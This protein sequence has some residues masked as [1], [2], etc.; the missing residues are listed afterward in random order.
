MEPFG[1][2]IFIRLLIASI[3]KLTPHSDYREELQSGDFF[4]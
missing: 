4:H 1:T 3:N 2:G